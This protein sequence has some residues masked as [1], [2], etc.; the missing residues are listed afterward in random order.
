MKAVI[1]RRSLQRRSCLLK[2]CYLKCQ[3]CPFYFKQLFLPVKMNAFWTEIVT[4]G[5]KKIKICSHSATDIKNNATFQKRK[6]CNVTVNCSKFQQNKK[7]LFN[8][9][10]GGQSKCPK[11]NFFFFAIL[12]SSFLW[13]KLRFLHS[14]GSFRVQN[15]KCRLGPK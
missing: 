7:N 11:S 3:N 12:V 2:N 9:N 8:R 5:D 4:S 15:L 1:N 13:S 6:L 14:I 10:F